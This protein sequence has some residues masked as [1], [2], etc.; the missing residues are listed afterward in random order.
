VS[1]TLRR[2]V[3]IMV[4]AAFALVA[5]SVGSDKATAETAVARFHDDFNSGRYHEMYVAAADD[6]RKA[7]TE[8]AFVSL[9]ANVKDRAGR[10]ESARQSSWAVNSGTSGTVVSLTYQVAFT[11]SSAIETFGWRM[12][13]GAAILLAY[14]VEPASRQ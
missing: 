7:T 1:D 14:R 9:L 6:F 8:S 11:Q 3:G 13:N 2:A 5:C 10:Y 12:E 4:F